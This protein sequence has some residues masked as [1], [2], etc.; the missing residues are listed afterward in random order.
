MSEWWL[1]RTLDVVVAGGVLV[2]SAP[3]LGI[4]AAAIKLDS[5][6]PIVFGHTRVGRNRLPIR[7]LK[8]RTMVS[9]ADKR[10][11][12]ITASRDP[13]IT[14]VGRWLRKTKLDE[15]PQLWNVIRGDM[16]LVGPRPEVP[17]FV[18]MYRP[19]WNALFTVRPGLTDLASIT[20][21]D[22]ESLLAAARDQERAYR[23]VIMPAKLELAVESVQKSSLG[24]DLRVLARTVM[25]IVRG[26]GPREDAVLADVKRR[27][28]QLNEGA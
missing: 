19:E 11:P 12:Q 1:K 20:F 16:S 21:R 24:H 5:P 14:R 8:L 28:Q 15:L 7:A 26:P 23:E 6:G 13:R 4:V 2:A 25:T 10:G 17:R 18:E 22:E 3:L 27:I 9:G